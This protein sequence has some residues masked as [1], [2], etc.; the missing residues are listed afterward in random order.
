[1]NMSYIRLLLSAERL[2][3]ISEQVHQQDL[4]GLI[5]FCEENPK[6][7]DIVVSQDKRPRE[8]RVNDNLAISILPWKN[9]LKKLW[10]AEIQA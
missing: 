2:I 9:F 7:R 8:L 6:A 10:N 1:M 3:K 4:K 5:A